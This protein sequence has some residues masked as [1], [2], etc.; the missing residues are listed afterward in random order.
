MVTHQFE[1]FFKGVV[2]VLLRGQAGTRHGSDGGSL[3]REEGGG[4]VREGE[5]GE[6]VGG[7]R[8]GVRGR[9][10]GRGG[11]WWVREGEREG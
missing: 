2:V 10:R 11:R 3:E 6:V 8:E 7:V 1:G 5:G 4:G 9:V